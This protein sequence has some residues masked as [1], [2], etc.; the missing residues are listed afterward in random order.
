MRKK[1]SIE[2]HEELKGL[3]EELQRMESGDELLDKTVEAGER[4]ESLR[5]QPVIPRK[6]LYIIAGLASLIVAVIAL[7]IVM[8]INNARNGN[9]VAVP[10]VVKLELRAAQAMI[11]SKNLRVRVLFNS[12]SKAAPG[13][14]LQQQPPAGTQLRSGNEVNLTVAGTNK[15]AIPAPTNVEPVNEITMPAVTGLVDTE[16]RRRLEALGMKVEIIAARD[17]S[18]REYMVLASDPSANSKIA[19]GSTVKLTV[20]LLSP[21]ADAN[22]RLLDYSGKSVEA[23]IAELKSLGFVVNSKNVLSRNYAIGKVAGTDPPAN[24][25]LAPGSTVTVLIAAQQ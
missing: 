24:S 1:P 2:N 16:A 20:N 14:V 18:Q 25:S 9:T 3:V 6:N 15:V 13:T 12:S 5:P 23:T 19:V 7:A 8:V 10:D 4:A 11:T 22:I 17:T 21:S